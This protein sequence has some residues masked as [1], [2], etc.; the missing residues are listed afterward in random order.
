MA[1]SNT[2]LD[3]LDFVITVLNHDMQSR[4]S[5]FVTNIRNDIKEFMNLPYDLSIPDDQ[6]LDLAVNRHNENIKSVIG[7]ENYNLLMEKMGDDN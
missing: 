7:V 4:T 1:L 5:Y 6:L 3:L 2:Q